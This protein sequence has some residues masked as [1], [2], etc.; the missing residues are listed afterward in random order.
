MPEIYMTKYGVSELHPAI[1]L[2][3]FLEKCCIRFADTVLTPNS[4]FRDLFVF[5]SCPPWKIHIVMNTP[6]ETVFNLDS[7]VVPTA[8]K[9][10]FV[11][12]YHGSILS[13]NGL[14]IALEAIERVQAKIPNLRFEVY[15]DG[16][17]KEK[18]LKRVNELNLNSIVRYH[19]PK[20]V[21]KIADAIKL[22][23]L[24]IIPN[25]KSVFTNLNLPVRIFEYLAMKKPVVAPCTQGIMD[26]FDENSLLFFEPG[27]VESLKD[28]I[29][30]AYH[31][32]L[33]CQHILNRG[34][35]IYKNH[36]WE[37]EKRH[38][39]DVVKNTMERNKNISKSQMRFAEVA[40]LII[41]SL[42]I[43]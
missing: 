4:A 25:K 9:N 35:N 12:M 5:R 30:D 28:I 11:I 7:S 8:K 38:L 10:G 36:R 34:L 17:F 22:C 16:D 32:P 23:T 33:R 29:L 15:G 43:N 19:G 27:N 20:P 3:K 18:F 31:N 6:Q 21:E 40:T 26:Y 14:D 2:I 39:I 13:Y 37:L 42:I 41:S 24:G 1:R